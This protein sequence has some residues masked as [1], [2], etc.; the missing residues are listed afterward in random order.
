MLPV[1]VHMVLEIR[2]VRGEKGIGAS[3]PKRGP[4]SRP[5]PIQSDRNTVLQYGWFL[6]V[7]HRK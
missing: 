5:R 4:A 7:N 3:D 6:S 1:R 2:S